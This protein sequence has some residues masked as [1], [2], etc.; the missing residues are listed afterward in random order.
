MQAQKKVETKDYG[1]VIITKDCSSLSSSRML[2]FS[3]FFFKHMEGQSLSW[4]VL[5]IGRSTLSYNVFRNLY[6]TAQG[7]ISNGRV[8]DY[9][10]S[11]DR[12]HEKMYE[13]LIDTGCM[14]KNSI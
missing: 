14:V 2:I 3:F 7:Q 6:K 11:T 1:I 9:G 4:R 10:Y 8:N 12:L 5:Q 13:V